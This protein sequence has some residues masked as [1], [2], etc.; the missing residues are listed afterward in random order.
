VLSYFSSWPDSA[1]SSHGPWAGPPVED[2]RQQTRFSRC[3]LCSRPVQ[4]PL[5]PL[6]SG[7][8]ERRRG[9]GIA[10]NRG[11]GR[12]RR[13][14]RRTR[15]GNA[16]LHAGG[17]PEVWI[18]LDLTLIGY[19]P[20]AQIGIS[21]FSPSSLLSAAACTVDSLAATGNRRPRSPSAGVAAA[22]PPP[23]PSL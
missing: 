3:V 9:A 6:P 21:Q 5:R 2:R 8:V 18:E 16:P 10:G 20:V 17:R 11:G 7:E 15:R 12:P 4:C 23:R 14:C 22:P 13:A 1:D 19:L